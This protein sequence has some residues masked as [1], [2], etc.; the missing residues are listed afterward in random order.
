MKCLVVFQ[1]EGPSEY[2]GITFYIL[3]EMEEAA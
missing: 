3:F 2:I 1:D